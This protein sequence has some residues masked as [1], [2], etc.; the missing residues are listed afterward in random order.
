MMPKEETIERFRLSPRQSHLWQLWQDSPSYRLQCRIGLRGRIEPD[1]LR[2]GL[3][4]AVARHSALR[5][6]FRRERGFKAPFQS[7]GSEASPL[8]RDIDLSGVAAGEVDSLLSVLQAAELE[9]DLDLADGPTLLATLVR[10]SDRQACLV[11]TASALVADSSSLLILAAETLGGPGSEEPAQFIQFSEWQSELL[12]Q[13]DAAIEEG[14]A[15]WRRRL[16]EQ[17]KPLRLAL[18]QQRRN[19]NHPFVPATVPIALSAS[20]H[21]ALERC[22]ERFQ[23]PPECLLLAAWQTLLARQSDRAAFS[24]WTAFDNRTSP[25]LAAMV[26]PLAQAAPIGCRVDPE[27]SFSV[28]VARTREGLLEAADW[29]ELFDVSGLVGDPERVGFSACELDT[30]LGAGKLGLVA[31]LLDATDRGDR[32]KLSLSCLR[33]KHFWALELVFDPTVLPRTEAERVALR[34]EVLLAAALAR[35]EGAIASLPIVG[36]LERRLLIEELNLTATDRTGAR[37]IHERIA[38]RSALSSTA[39]AVRCGDRQ[40]SFGDLEAA[41]NRWSGALR[42]RGLRTGDLVALCVE[43]SPELVVWLL[44]ILKAG[45]AYMALDPSYPRERL[46]AM[47]ED[48]RPRIL[49]TERRWLDRLPAHDAALLLGAELA[50]EVATLEG[51]PVEWVTP[52]ELAYVLFTSGSTGRPKGVM[53]THR[54]LSNYLE[55]AVAAYEVAAGDGA[56]VHS[57]VGFD[58]T[59][60]SLFA[61]L[62]A[63]CEIRLLPEDSGPEALAAELRRHSGFS[64]VKVT[65]SHFEV[66]R[67]GLKPGDLGSSTG[68][69]VVGG[70]ALYWQQVA[71]WRERAPKTRIVNEYGPTETVVGCCVY[72]AP[73]AG[74]ARSGPVPIGRPIANTRLYVVDRTLDLVPFGATGE[75]A[76]GGA[77]I[78]RG[79]LRRPGTTAEKFVPDPFGGEP[80]ERLYRTGDLVRYLA[81]G[82]LEFVGRTDQQ[83]KIRGHRI[84]L[85]EIESVLRAH[86]AV[87]EACVVARETTAGDLQLAAYVVAPGEV[88]DASLRS[89]LAA[90]VP[91]VMVPGALI[92]LAEM[93]LDRHGKVDRKL[94]PVPELG[95]AGNGTAPPR[96]AL[97]ARLAGLWGEVLGREGIGV[98]DRFFVLGGVSIRAVRLISRINEQESAELQLPD[99]FKNQT[100]AA[101]ATHLAV[102]GRRS[103]LGRARELGLER[104]NGLAARILGDELQRA[105]LPEAFE[106]ILPLSGIEKG[107]LYYSL[108]MLDQPIYHDQFAYLF[109]IPDTETFFHAFKLATQRH[110]ILRSAFQLY[111]FEEPIKIV[112]ATASFG[113]EV[114]DLRGLDDGE[115]QRRIAAYRADDLARKFDPDGQVLWRLKLFRLTGDVHCVVWSWHHAILDG[116]SNLSLWVE[117]NDLCARDDLGEIDRLPPLKS[118]YRDYLAIS[119]GRSASPETERFWRAAMAGHHRSKLPF[120]RAKT[121][122]PL[123]VGMGARELSLGGELL[124]QLRSLA[125]D[126]HVSLQTLCFGAHVLLLAI[127]AVEADPVTGLVTHDRPPIQDGD[128]ILGCFLNSLPVRVEPGAYATPAALIAALHAF[129]TEVREH[130]IPLVDIAALIGQRTEGGNPIFDTLFN[131]MDFHV[132]ERVRDN[133]LFRPM[134][135]EE[136]VRRFELRS[137]EMTNTLFDVEVSTTLDRFFVRIKFSPRHFELEDIERALLLYRRILERFARDLDR[138]LGAEDLLSAEEIDQ[139]VRRF[140]DTAREFRDSTP[141]HR[142]FEERA[143][144]DS[145]K[146]AVIAGTR[147]ITY[148]DLAASANRLAHRLLA[149]GVAPGDRVGVIF[150]RSI[151]LATALL[152]VLKCGAVY[153]P[154]E[155]DYPPARKAHIIAQSKI[156]RVVADRRYEL[157]AGAPRRP[158]FV[159]FQIGEPLSEP[160]TSLAIAPAPSDL[161]YT[162]YTSGSTGQPKGVMIEHRSAVNLI[163]WVNRLWEVGPDTRILMLSSICFDL[164]VW[165]LFGGLAAGATVIIAET[166]DLRDPVRLLDL[167][168]ASRAT[169]WNSVPSTLGLLVQHLEDAHPEFRGDALRTI[170][171]SGDWI[172]L[173]LPQRA[174][175]FFPNARLVS[176]GGATEATVWSIY[177]PVDRHDRAWVSVP[178]GRPIDNNTFYI[179]DDQLDLVPS[180]VVGT[181]YIGG[182]GVAAGYEGDPIKTSS[183]FVPDRFVGVG[184][185]M[186]RTGDLGRMMADGNIEFLGRA[187]HQV[188]I[189]GFRVELG[190]VESQLARHPALREAVVVD[191]ADRVGDKYLCAYFVA[192]EP[193]AAADLRAFLAET[194]P[195]YMI[196]TVYVALAAIP[197]TANGKVDRR[198]LP[199]PDPSN[200]SGGA[201]F[202]APHLGVE[203]ALGELW[204]EILGVAGIGRQHNFFELGGHSLSAVQLV[205]RIRRRFF[206]DLPL[207]DFFAAPTLGDLA[208]RIAEEAAG[209]AVGPRSF[210]DRR[211]DLAPLSYPQNRIWFLERLQPESGAFNMP[212]ALRLVG[213]LDRPAL[214]A[215]FTEIERRHEILRT[216][217]V[218]VEGQLYQ[219]VEA[220]RALTP[221]T[222]DLDLLPTRRR[223]VEIERVATIEARRPF[224]L[225]RG[226]VWRSSLLVAGED[227]AL[228]VNLHHI[229]ADGWSLGVLIREVAVLYAAFVAGEPSPFA[230]LPAQYADYASWQRDWCATAEGGRQL[231]YWRRQLAGEL[232]ALSLPERPQRGARTFRAA[233]VPWTVSR[234]V[235]DGVAALA[236]TEEATPFMV[237]LSAFA[238]VLA[239]ATG[240]DDLIIGTNVANRNFEELEGLIGFFVNDLALRIDLSGDP[241]FR[242][243]IGRTRATALAAYAHQEVPIEKL[244]EV[245]QPDRQAAST[246]LFQVQFLLQNFAVDVH[247]LP[248]LRIAPIDFSHAAAPFDLTFLVFESESGLRGSLTY[249]VDRYETPLAER[250]VRAYESLLG[251]VAAHPDRRLGELVA[252]EV[253]AVA[254]GLVAA[255]NDEI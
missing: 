131:F 95:I 238:V 99:L 96:T 80:G 243:L 137:S 78:A 36:S 206:V 65:P 1:R 93:P 189:R 217:F 28:L 177:F 207:R 190:E 15:F 191:R 219:R 128:R 53:V 199:E 196:P 170:F 228:L 8:W 172:P 23:A 158:D 135:S 176:L 11:L 33:M 208:R 155:P 237:L 26:G 18:E 112:L 165:D 129:R 76:I 226:P 17:G 246:P 164:S 49:L 204:E 140:N 146:P 39:T 144:E 12:A 167:L 248:G 151:E 133:V 97:E 178:Y 73:A 126:R 145:T 195:E 209:V 9:S 56:P 210:R 48:G 13:E 82:D 101:L 184:A 10:Q 143:A 232:P 242:S 249:S 222:V 182:I 32:F 183:S 64:L 62:L 121:R 114:E 6:R 41:A 70:E 141:M 187:D 115:Q 188:K 79:Y 102:E 216:R 72:E 5:L 122:D 27:E 54:G 50:D 43:R 231:E 174:R 116:W 175:R 244:I 89:H 31:E 224:D 25:D 221:P 212:G 230:E 142:A 147:A 120:N 132:A 251:A 66:L 83:V 166:V 119:L 240:Q 198:A 254:A 20:S 71:E 127:T 2:D 149:S 211:S 229:A 75:L 38:E 227:S 214:A 44:A 69:L 35:P 58:L 239:Q 42:R 94:L 16:A 74:G 85:G 46:A 241:T 152:A 215:V 125:L 205:S 91:E 107:M 157:P 55:W 86:P 7:V 118:G 3:A 203:A 186:Y 109:S 87:S 250:L 22:A 136:M 113:S 223:S 123:A 61:P 234:Q 60:T 160:A 201:A 193:P 235:V 156:D 106:E 45:G 21:T 154:L 68:V 52:D 236:R 134:G 169:F 225:E 81:N 4:V 19:P 108:L 90:F 180:G 218:E 202:E 253:D 98:D 57:A 14:K 117:M 213:F 110:G 104:I 197:L 185:R 173:S 88:S 138:P 30:D 161:A 255:F 77:G 245:L 130:E 111:R 148:G 51:E 40:L 84:E 24:I 220:P 63:G 247:E 47:L 29:S 105:L 67:H 150:E 200:I 233:G 103:P 179:L 153:V 59:V 92:R 252:P 194:L 192:G 34:F 181:L 100:V 168:V 162:I 159:L 37:P 163:E 171:L 139:V 124:S